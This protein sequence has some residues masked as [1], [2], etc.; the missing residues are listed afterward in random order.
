MRARKIDATQAEIVSALRRAGCL[1]W[2]VNGA[3]DLVVQRGGEIY[4]LECKSKRGSLTREQ[5][6]MR[7]QGWRY[8]IVYSPEAALDA[9]GLRPQM[10]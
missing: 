10:T 3:L 4:L 1:V 7:N 2:P 9:V 8:S 5:E 6:D